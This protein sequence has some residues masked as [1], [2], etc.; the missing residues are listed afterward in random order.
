MNTRKTPF[1]VVVKS[2]FSSAIFVCQSGIVIKYLETGMNTDYQSKK[3]HTKKNSF[4][5]FCHLGISEV[6][7][8]KRGRITKEKRI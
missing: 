2:Y 6:E 1:D 5:Y 3:N 7:D 4:L 8:F